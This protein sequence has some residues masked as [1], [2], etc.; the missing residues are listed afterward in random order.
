[1]MR[2]HLPSILVLTPVIQE[3]TSF[4]SSPWPNDFTW[5]V[6]A[7]TPSA[8]ASIRVS[9]LS[10]ACFNTPVTHSTLYSMLRGILPN[11]VCGPISI[12]ILGKPST[13]T[14][15]EVS[16]PAFQRSLRR[17]PFIPRISMR[18]KAPVTASKPVA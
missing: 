7:L 14:P 12:A 17:R 1:M 13:I 3:F 9:P 6:Q 15:S 11:A 18:S 2:T 5:S 10:W 8:L 16:G 4:D